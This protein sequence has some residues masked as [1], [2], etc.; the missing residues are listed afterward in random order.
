MGCHVHNNL[1]YHLHAAA[2]KAA[3]RIPP[4]H[5]HQPQT[6]FHRNQVPADP[7]LH[8]CH[9]HLAACQCPHQDC[10]LQ[11]KKLCFFYPIYEYFNIFLKFMLYDDKKYEVTKGELNSLG[12]K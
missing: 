9:K 3:S 1:N 11:T 2:R 4:M 6:G 5:R 7:L 10:P 12:K 8:L